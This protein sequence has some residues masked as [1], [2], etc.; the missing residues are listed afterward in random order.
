VTDVV[1][2]SRVRVLPRHGSPVVVRSPELEALVALHVHKNPDY[3]KAKHFGFKKRVPRT[4]DTYREE[5]GGGLSFPRGSEW[6]VREQL[7][8]LWL[9]MQDRRTLG[10]QDLGPIPPHRPPSGALWPHQEMLVRRALEAETALVRS[11]SASGKTTAALALA[12]R[13]NLP[14]LVVVHNGNLFDQW[15]ARC[16]AELGVPRSWVG[17]IRGPRRKLGPITVGMQQTLYGCADEVAPA[18]GM[19]IV[20]EV[21]RA[22]SRTFLEVVDRMTAKYRVGVSDDERRSDGKEFLIYD[23]FGPVVG[24]ASH[25]ELVRQGYVM[26]V[27]VRVVPTE[28]R[29]DWYAGLE[30]AEKLLAYDQLL[31][32]MAGDKLR[33]LLALRDVARS[34][35]EG[36]Q[37]IVFTS[38]VEHALELDRQSN[39]RGVPSGFVVGEEQAESAE[40]LRRFADRRVSAVYGTYQY[41]GTGV[42]M[43]RATRGVFVMPIANNTKGR[44][45]F[46][47]Y[48]GRFARVADGKAAPELTYLWDRHVFGPRPLRHLCSWANDVRVEWRGA[49]VPGRQ[50][51]KEIELDE[52]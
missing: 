2:D 38:R 25:D 35:L 7:G 44:S 47:Q 29:A 48:R 32:A 41:L 20:D 26:D 12:A 33:N 24:E 28:F 31:S 16:S 13:A 51:L 5:D 43:P 9:R 21:Q 39:A 34:T 40:T 37:V 1:V 8:A 10:D 42:D 4:I 18:F 49:L 3:G 50:V 17:T 14:T 15:L 52:T 19:V 27:G 36:H 22:A 11:A 23:L 45:Q 6:K 46:K 30:D